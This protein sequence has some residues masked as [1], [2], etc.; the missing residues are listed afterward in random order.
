MNLTCI[1]L[2]DDKDCD[3]L[4][5][6]LRKNL[7]LK[8][9]SDFLLD[10]ILAVNS[11][12]HLTE[13]ILKVANV[14]WVHEINLEIDEINLKMDEINLKIMKLISILMKLQY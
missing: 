1:V 14:I 12:S 11:L 3:D 8:F 4:L 9:L 13:F 5:H 2:L 6:S 10:D 7:D